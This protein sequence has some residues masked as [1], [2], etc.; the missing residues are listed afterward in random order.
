MSINKYFKE[1]KFNYHY[2]YLLIYLF[3]RKIVNGDMKNKSAKTTFLSYG[4]AAPKVTKKIFIY[5]PD[6]R[7]FKSRIKMFNQ[8]NFA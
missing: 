3:F 7:V 4:S 1:Y 2:C 8:Y 5:D 6:Y